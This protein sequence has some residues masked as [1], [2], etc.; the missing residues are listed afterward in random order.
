[1]KNLMDVLPRNLRMTLAYDGTHYVGW[2]TQANGLA[3]QEVIEKAIWKLTKEN[4]SLLSTGRTDSGVH[5]LGQVASFRT[6]SRIPADGMHKA[7]QNFLPDDI[8][9]RD[10][11]EAH[12]KFHATFSAKYKR[13]RYVINNG[14][15]NSPF[16]RQ[17]SWHFFASLDAQ[18]MHEAAQVIVGK[19]DFRSFETHWPNKATSVRTVMSLTVQRQRFCPLWFN[20][21]DMPP[22]TDNVGDYIWIEIVADGFLYNMV[23]TIVGTLVSVGRGRWDGG[24]V[25]R[26]I[27]TMD[28]TVAGDTAPP[29]GLYL[30]DVCYD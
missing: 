17:Y 18:A 20:A 28:R 29:Q 13:Y 1:M 8:L 22:S 2:Q 9:I 24:D 21:A 12:P 7:I 6:L 5:A 14:R 16:F 23:R 11:S 4:V 10:M 3:I 19:Q 15:T 25:R 30:V 26:I 27:D